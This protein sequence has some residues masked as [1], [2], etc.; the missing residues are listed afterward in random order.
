MPELLAPAGSMEKLK[1]ALHYGADAVY[2]G[3]ETFGLRAMGA[4]FSLAEMPEALQR[5][6]D[7]GSRAYLTVNS[8]VA[9]HELD[10]L[11]RLLESV[12]PLPFDAFIV[13]DPGVIQL[14]R[15][16]A[17]DAVLHLSTQANT[18][19]WRS[20]LFWQE[21]G[22]RRINLA[23][24][25]TLSDLEET[26]KRVGLELEVFVHGALCIAYSGRCLLSSAM[27]GR[28]ANRGACTHPCRWGY[29]LVE[30]KRPGEY[31]PILEDG[32][33]S[34]ILNSRDL[35]LID[36]LPRLVAAGVD[37]LKIEGRMKGVHYLASTLRVY[38]QALDLIAQSPTDFKPDPLWHDELAALTRRGYT[39]GFLLG[40]PND[41]AQ[42]YTAPQRRDIKFVGLVLEA[43]TDGTVVI[44]VRG[45]FSAD[46]ELEVVGRDIS[47]RTFI[48]GRLLTPEGREVYRA[49][50][51]Q[52]LILT[53]PFTLEP[54]DLVRRRSY[55]I[56]T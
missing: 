19:N 15:S 43:R 35:C 5:T 41:E 9:T 31:F 17:P 24:E 16:L 54:Y 33:G 22:I 14:I 52:H 47:P 36:H 20:A 45:P 56:A 2:L 28:S 4:N 49:D 11:Q 6:H 29:S 25:T 40:P 7:A 44:Q 1:I 3:G 34:F 50:P 18:T 51:N 8:Y 23:R 53:P 13:S 46:D 12:L 21:S 26:R 37:S 42:E 38:R 39:T 48:P 27:T 55:D 30:E 10:Q 32:S